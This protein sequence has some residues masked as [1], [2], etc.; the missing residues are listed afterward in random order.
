MGGVQSLIQ[1]TALHQA[2]AREF[3]GLYRGFPLGLTLVGHG[4]PS[5]PSQ[6]GTRS[7][8]PGRTQRYSLLLHVRFPDRASPTS[9]EPS[10]V[11]GDCLQSLLEQG[12]ARV[13]VEARI[14]W[15][16]LYEANDLVG[17]EAV[18]NILNAFIDGLAAAGIQNAGDR[19]HYCGKTVVKEPTYVAERV[20]WIC[21]ACF[22]AKIAEAQPSEP[23]APLDGLRLL[24]AAG[25]GA[26]LGA[27][28]WA[29]LWIGHER[30][31]EWISKRHP[32][33]TIWVPDIAL[34]IL[35]VGAGSFV[36]G[37]SGV[38]VRRVAYQGHTA[39]TVS[40]CGGAIAAIAMGEIAWVLWLLPQLPGVRAAIRFLPVV[41]SAEGTMHYVLRLMV[42][43]FSVSFAFV[44]AK[45]S[46]RRVDI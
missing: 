31:M 12:Q 7:T 28:A 26:L 37:P 30:V 45:P 40:S 10:Y 35:A 8:D 3:Y 2:N 4:L 27:A 18:V 41:W 21:P 20:A 33:T 16:T 34:A 22:A 15:L 29:G 17:S 11:W 14:A 42:A 1:R 23:A 9:P 19:C 25:L 24:L 46:R 32:S 38:L 43:I 44:V 39:R 5:L 6:Q 13:S 36:G